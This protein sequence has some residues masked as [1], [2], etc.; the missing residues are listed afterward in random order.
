MNLFHRKDLRKG[1]TLVL[2]AWLLFSTMYMLSK[3]I[4]GQTTV[5][6]M[7]FFRN[8]MGLVIVLPYIVKKRLKAFEIK[9]WR[10]VLTRSLLGL[11]NLVL[12]FLAV[13]R[14]SLVNTTLLNNSAPFFVPFVLWFWL[15][16]PI[17]HKMWPAILAG[18][19]GIALILKPDQKIFNLGAAY[20]LLSGIFLAVNLVMMRLTSKS[21]NL[22]SFLLYFFLI[23]G[24][25]T[26]PFA[27]SDW[28]IE[29]FSTLIALLSIGFCS[30]LGQVFLYYGMKWGKAH[31]L[32]PLTYSTVIF[33]GIYEWLLWGRIPDPIAYVGMALIIAAGIWIVLISPSTKELK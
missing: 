12:I 4:G 22:Y 32:A 20:A 3:L 14:I 9:N 6:T 25:I 17:N 10:I 11:I 33:S 31:Q 24:I 8:V 18:F 28:K 29:G 5:P 2:I 23:G 30:C 19:I 27:L 1:I 13:K 26:L 16:V 15:K 21:E 7:L